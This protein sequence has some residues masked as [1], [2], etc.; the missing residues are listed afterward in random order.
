MD[1]IPS[2]LFCDI[3]ELVDF[4]MQIA[5]VEEMPDL[6]CKSLQLCEYL[7]GLEISDPEVHAL[8][9]EL[10]QNHLSGEGT[11]DEERTVASCLEI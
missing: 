1:S 7:A 6:E 8:I 9:E 4:F 11:S 10:K 5:E 2:E 3:I